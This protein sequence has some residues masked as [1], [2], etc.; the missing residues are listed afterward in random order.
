MVRRA[1]QRRDLHV[2]SRVNEPER[3]RIVLAANVKGITVSEWVRSTMLA[4]SAQVLAVQAN[5]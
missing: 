4:A 1:S 3:D 5:P 2:F